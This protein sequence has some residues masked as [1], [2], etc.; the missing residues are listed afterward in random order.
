MRILRAYRDLKVK[1]S[2]FIRKIQQ[3]GG[4]TKEAFLLLKKSIDSG[5]EL[6]PEEKDKIGE[7][8]K[9]V[10]KTVGLVGIALLPG[11]SVFFILTKFFKLNKY[12]LPSAF[13]DK[14][15]ITTEKEI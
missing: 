7:Q 5:V 15:K 6:T 10:L 9:D 4:E 2:D 12:V 14:E 3:E 8:L 13:E 1:A 11:G